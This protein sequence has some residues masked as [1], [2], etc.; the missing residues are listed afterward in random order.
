LRNEFQNVSSFSR[1]AKKSEKPESELF[2]EEPELYQR[3]LCFSMVKPTANAGHES[4][5]RDILGIS[6]N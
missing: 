3:G 4:S 1:K 2:L 6:Q 5:W